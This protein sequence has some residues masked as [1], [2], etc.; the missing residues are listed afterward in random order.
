MAIATRRALVL[1][2]GGVSGIAWEA[3]VLMGL[4]DGGVDVTT[5]DRVIGTSAGS[6]VGARLLGDARLDD[7][8]TAQAEAPPGSNDDWVRTLGGRLGAFTLLAGRRRRLSWLP[9]L[10]LSGVGLETLVRRAARRRTA[11]RWTG[12]PA[13]HVTD[14]NPAIARIGELAIAARTAPESAFVSIVEALLGPAT[15]WPDRFAVTAVDA[16]TGSTVVFDASSG[17]PL[18][19]AVAASCALPTVL[20]PVTIGGRPYV[21]GG[22]ASE[23]HLGLAAGHDEVLAIMPVDFGRTVAE[24]EALRQL[25]ARFRAIHP[26]PASR[27]AIGH[28]IEL[29][30]PDRR[31]RSALAGRED[32]LQAARDGFFGGVLVETH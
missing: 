8:Y 6:I 10:W 32:G 17:V 31:A 4:R 21:D 1:G 26:G 15:D 7:F 27:A 23:V 19:H 24:A 22:V 14:P 9:R 30:D 16:L 20:P 2:G 3:G 25:G 12:R 13:P 29:L 5:W 28:D 18:A 11:G